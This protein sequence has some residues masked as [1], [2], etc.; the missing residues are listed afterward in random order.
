[1]ALTDATPLNAVLAELVAR[2]VL[3]QSQADAVLEELEARTSASRPMPPDTAALASEPGPRRP[4]SRMSGVLVEAAAYLGAAL[5]AASAVAFVATNWDSLTEGSRL[6]M[7]LGV[8]VLATVAGLLVVR[9]RGGRAALRTHVRASRRRLASVLF[10]FGAVAIAVGIG[11]LLPAGEE[12][13]PRAGSWL[14]VVCALIVFVLVIGAQWLS[15]SAVTE[16]ALFG[17]LTVLVL[18]L[19]SFAVPVDNPYGDWNFEN[20]PPPL[21]WFDLVGPLA[22]IALGLV[23]AIIAARLLTLPM[24][25][26]F[27]GVVLALFGAISMAAPESSRGLGL[28]ALGILA[29]CGIG[30]FM[31]NRLWPWL[32]LSVASVAA[33]VFL[34]VAQTGGAVTAFLAS[35]L[36]L[37]AGAGAA[38]WWGNRSSGGRGTR[39]HGLTGAL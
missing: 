23:W 37:L 5:V 36:V 25:A 7:L 33:L 39:P 15:P 1:M 34:A 22:A 12:Q 13:S 18:Q 28:V 27:L 31:G 14:T 29:T 19:A 32:A 3:S 6:V 4:P 24:L 8:G 10:T 11:Q 30:M 35:G 2:R 16:L 21:K 17:S 26:V 38:T 20:G 9:L